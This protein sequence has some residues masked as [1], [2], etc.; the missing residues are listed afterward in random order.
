MS[1][2]CGNRGEDTGRFHNIFSTCAAPW[3]A[4]WIFLRKH[5]DSL[6]IYRELTTLGLGNLHLSSVVTEMGGVMPEQYALLVFTSE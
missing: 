3:D 5:S 2:C 6:P 1:R 4:F